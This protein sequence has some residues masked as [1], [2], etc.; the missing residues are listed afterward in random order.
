M[1]LEDPLAG[2][3]A[4]SA[5]GGLVPRESPLAAGASEAWSEKSDMLKRSP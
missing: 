3:S 4:W 1:L 5:S 2:T